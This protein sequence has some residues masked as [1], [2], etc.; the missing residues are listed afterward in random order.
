MARRPRTT[1]P[2][3]TPRQPPRQQGD[4]HHGRVWWPGHV[5]ADRRGWVRQNRMTA[6]IERNGVAVCDA[7]QQPMDWREAKVFQVDGKLMVL[8]P[9][10]GHLHWLAR[11]IVDS[12]WGGVEG[13]AVA[14]AM[15]A[16]WA[17]P[18]PPVGEPR[19]SETG[20]ELEVDPFGATPPGSDPPVHQVEVSA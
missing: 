5:L 6:F 16:L 11:S 20:E 12:G 18:C 1:K 10:H 13:L 9:L 8:C 15:G 7:G 2:P 3:A 4:V 14:E 17:A 19:I